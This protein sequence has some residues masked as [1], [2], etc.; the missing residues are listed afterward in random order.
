M[1]RWFDVTLWLRF[2]GCSVTPSAPGKAPSVANQ[3]CAWEGIIHPPPL[4]V[5]NAWS[6]LQMNCSITFYTWKR[7]RTKGTGGFFFNVGTQGFFDNQMHSDVLGHC[8]SA[9]LR[10]SSGFHEYFWEGVSGDFCALRFS[11]NPSGFHIHP[12]AKSAVS[13]RLR[14]N[15]MLGVSYRC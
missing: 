14:L 4:I 7:L 6:Y 1:W 15:P 5:Y 8:Y 2:R 12:N 9:Q 11:L 13:P 3:W 10:M